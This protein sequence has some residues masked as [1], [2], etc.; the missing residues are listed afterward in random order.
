MILT[1]ARIV[2]TDEVIEGTLHIEQDRIKTV[3][4]GRV[5]IPGAIDC[6][7]GFVLPGLIEL[8]TDNMEKYFAPRPGVEW[9]GISAVKIHDAQMISAGI[10]TV[11]D[12]ISIGDI[13][14]ESTRLHSLNRMVNSL[15]QARERGFLRADHQLHFRCEVSHA[16]TLSAFELIFD[17]V[18]AQL[19]SLMDHSPGQRQFADLER[20]R[21]YYQGK[22]KLSDAEL[23]EFIARK[24]HA[25]S[26]YS[27]SHRDAICEI[28]L[29]HG[30]PLASHDDATSEHVAEACSYKM[31]IAE[32]PTT[33][34]AA[35]EAH[36]QG[37]CVLMGAPN[38]MRGESHSGNVA[39]HELAGEGLLDALS[40]DYYPTSLLESV[41]RLAA[42]ETNDYDLP[43]A[44][45]LVSAGP[46]DAVGLTNRGRIEP[47]AQADLLWVSLDS[48][49]EVRIE[50]VWKAGERVY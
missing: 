8:H 38:V 36:A 35:R 17:S 4:Q 26:L 20:Y 30:I 47:G 49:Q 6:A 32:F 3:E 18:G 27:Q 7:G 33:L 42:M 2:L 45:A 9:P 29:H 48:H 21:K 39:A 31:S 40:S 25:S 5:S 50:H 22:H 44:V 1:N 13:A 15:I 24:I 19:V 12:A 46:A 11:F 14:D 41:F 16:E 37:L 28:C 10:T 43:K 23:E 34:V